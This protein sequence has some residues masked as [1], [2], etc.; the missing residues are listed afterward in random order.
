MKQGGL[1]TKL[2]V[3]TPL[4]LSQR[5]VLEDITP[6]CRDLPRRLQ[7]LPLFTGSSIRKPWTVEFPVYTKRKT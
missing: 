4:L 6:L 3:P 5:H 7:G 1:L 2:D